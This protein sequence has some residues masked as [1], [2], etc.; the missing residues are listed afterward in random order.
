[1]RTPGVSERPLAAASGAGQDADEPVE[2]CWSFDMKFLKF[3]L[4]PKP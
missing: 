4:N 2:T 1:M 3:T